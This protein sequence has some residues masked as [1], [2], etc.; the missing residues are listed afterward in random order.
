[1]TRIAAFGVACVM[2]VAIVAVWP[3][4]FFMNWDGNQKG[5]G[6]EYHLLALGI[7]ITLIIIGA[8]AWSLDSALVGP[9]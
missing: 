3:H 5:E 4:G 1:L 9:R 7:A 2:L 6:F 8:G